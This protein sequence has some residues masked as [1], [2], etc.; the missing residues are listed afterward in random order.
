[1]N[2][3]RRKEG[4]GTRKEGAHDKPFGRGAGRR[5]GP[6]TYWGN[7]FDLS[8]SHDV[9][10]HVT[11]R[12]VTPFPIGTD[13]EIFSPKNLCAQRDTRKCIKI[14]AHVRRI[15]AAD[16][17]TVRLHLQRTVSCNHTTFN[18]DNTDLD[19]DIPLYS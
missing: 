6:Q 10:D 19:D 15:T 17:S 14:R 8:R 3:H 16:V 2:R 1:V 18:A 12:T 9:I 7:D 13:F 5:E 4:V 11:V